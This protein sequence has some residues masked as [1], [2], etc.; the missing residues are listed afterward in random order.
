MSQFGELVTLLNNSSESEEESTQASSSSKSQNKRGL[1][2]L[3][4][5]IG[6]FDS[7]ELIENE[8]NENHKDYR[9]SYKR[10]TID[11]SKHFYR[12]RHPTYRHPT[13]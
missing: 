8:I 6:T 11:G 1:N 2:K 10:K 4:C 7:K 9:L 3:Y 13:Y 5:I 12:C